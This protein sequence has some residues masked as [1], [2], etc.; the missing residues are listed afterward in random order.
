MD[1]R[2]FV[3]YTKQY[4]PGKSE[5][6]FF[7]RKSSILRVM[8]LLDKGVVIKYLLRE[9]GWREKNCAPSPSLENNFLGTF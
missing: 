6:T 1:A 4:G 9:E 2:N 8:K 3:V 7:G 5:I